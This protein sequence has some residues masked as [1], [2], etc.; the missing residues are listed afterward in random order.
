MNIKMKVRLG[1]VSN[2]SSSSFVC[3]GMPIENI[4]VSNKTWLEEYRKLIEYREKC[5]SEYK[6]SE[7]PRDTWAT[8]QY[9]NAIALL[10]KTKNLHTEEEKINFIK[11]YFNNDVQEIIHSDDLNIGGN[12]DGEGIYIGL[13]PDA[14]CD[15]Y[16]NIKFGE[17]KSFVAK[18]INEFFGTNFIEKDIEYTE[19]GWYNG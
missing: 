13:T 4:P 5:I 11:N 16:P 12:N 9:N 3:W 10:E 7:N 8:H 2:S 15:K 17:V 19:Q 18:K 14:L 1:F 6:S